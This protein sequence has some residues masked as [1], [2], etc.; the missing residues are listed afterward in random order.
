MSVEELNR[1]L[2]EEECADL[3]GIWPRLRVLRGLKGKP[4]EPVH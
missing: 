2:P 4:G 1:R 3:D